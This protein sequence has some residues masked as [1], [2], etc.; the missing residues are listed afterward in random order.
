MY[1]SG[2]KCT[3]ILK[4]KVRGFV[5][6]ATVPNGDD[7]G[8]SVVGVLVAADVL[9]LVLVLAVLVVVVV[10]KLLFLSLFC[11][12]NPQ[13][14]LCSAVYGCMCICVSC[15]VSGG[16]GICTTHGT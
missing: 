3:S 14:V 16:C 15:G 6:C 1:A 9:V 12:V 8:G 7:G 2:P 5:A 13:S 10:P 4:V 11:F